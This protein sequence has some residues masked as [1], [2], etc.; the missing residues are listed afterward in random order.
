MLRAL[1]EHVKQKIA[2]GFWNTLDLREL[3][4]LWWR[5]RVWPFR[6]NVL[7]PNDY[8]YVSSNSLKSSVWLSY[9]PRWFFSLIIFLASWFLSLPL[10]FLIDE[11]C[12]VTQAVCFPPESW[13]WFQMGGWENSWIQ[14]TTK[15]FLFTETGWKPLTRT[16]PQTKRSGSPWSG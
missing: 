6:S 14:L 9:L 16:W 13:Q 2:N 3:L 10:L 15:M 7:K 12:K 1:L 5:L 4:S 8:E 11:L